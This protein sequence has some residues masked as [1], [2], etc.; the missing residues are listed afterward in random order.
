[1]SSADSA[2]RCRYRTQRR[3]L[4]LYSDTWCRYRTQRRLPAN[5]LR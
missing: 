4:A 5:V 3:V 2:M 1:M